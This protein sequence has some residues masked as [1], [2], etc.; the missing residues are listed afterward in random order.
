MNYNLWK[1]KYHCSSSRLEW[2]RNTWRSSLMVVSVSVGIR[3]GALWIWKRTA[4]CCTRVCREIIRTGGCVKQNRWR[5]FKRLYGAG[6]DHCYRNV[7]VWQVTLLSSCY[8]SW[9]Q[10]WVCSQSETIRARPRNHSNRETEVM[11]GILVSFVTKV[12][13]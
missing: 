11:K 5:Q 10:L 4:N 2:I 1:T 12:T 3:K 13:L 9:L 7:G 8:M 6:D